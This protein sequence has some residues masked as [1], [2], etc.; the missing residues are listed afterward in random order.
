MHGHLVGQCRLACARYLVGLDLSHR[1]LCSLVEVSSRVCLSGVGGVLTLVQSICT[2]STDT[3]AMTASSK[4]VLSAKE[5]LVILSSARSEAPYRLQARSLSVEKTTSWRESPIRSA[6][7]SFKMRRSGPCAPRSPPQPRIY[8]PQ[9]Q[10]QTSLHGAP[11]LHNRQALLTTS[12]HF[13][14]QNPSITMFLNGKD[15]QG[16]DLDTKE[17]LDRVSSTASGQEENGGFVQEHKLV[18]QLK[19]RH[20]AM[21]R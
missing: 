19:N 10:L 16:K 12:L 8:D 21:I 15:E 17:K 5:G 3:L 6:V 9:R 18:R 1:A 4:E 13:H 14:P 7:V 11:Q 2:V 20:I